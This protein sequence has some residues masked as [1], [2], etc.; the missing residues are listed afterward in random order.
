MR[1]W[2]VNV[3]EPLPTDPGHNRPWRAGLVARAL[4]ARGHECTWWSSTVQHFRKEL[5]HDQ[6]TV[7]EAGDGL[8]VVQLHGGL[9][10]RNIGLARLR[11]HRRLGRRFRDLAPGRPAPDAVF[12]SI[13][14]LELAREA[15]RYGRARGIPVMVDIRDQW[16]DFMAEQVPPLLR[17]AARL[18]LRPLYRDLDEACRG[19]SALCGN[20]PS[21]LDWGL[22][23][24]GREAGP[25]DR[26]RPHAYPVGEF[27]ADLL[28]RAGEFWDGLGVREGDPLPTLCFIGSLNFTAFDFAALVEGAR[29]LAG[30]AR[31][32]IAGSGTG[33]ER[34]RGLVDGAGNVVLAGWVDGPA[35]QVLMQRS[36]LGVT[37]YRNRANFV[38]NLPNKFLEYMS[39]GLPV[40][41]CLTGYSQS[42][43]AEAGCGAFYG[44]GDAAGFAAAAAGL[45]E[46]PARRALMAAAARAVFRERFTADLVYGQLVDD[47]EALA[48]E[49]R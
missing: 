32:V 4:A 38:G 33:Q 34:L 19:A 36:T 20:A 11:N 5:R 47:L 41:S 31:L 49:A 22:A 1:F 46:D 39:Q 17:P 10:R 12:A 24:A 25:R 44:E 3:N 27:P 9:Y 29:R 42:V 8:T 26:Y 28:R 2:I 18:A 15:V 30:R 14:I 6:D 48:R 23:H 40:L 16:P 45:L 21:F 35:L 37:P 43:L 7:L 13:P